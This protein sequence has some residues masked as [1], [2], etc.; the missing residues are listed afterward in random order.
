MVG[1]PPGCPD[2]MVTFGIEDET[3]ARVVA[4]DASGLKSE[5]GDVSELALAAPVPEPPIAEP[6][7]LASFG[8]KEE[9]EAAGTSLVLS[10]IT[11]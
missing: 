5:V 9:G 8:V 6:Y 1:E 2:G 4:C 3:S 7:A 10:S 11:A